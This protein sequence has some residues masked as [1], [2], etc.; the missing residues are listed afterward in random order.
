M[1]QSSW[2]NQPLF[3]CSTFKDM[4]AERDHL[5]DVVFPELERRLRGKKCH[6]EPVDLRWGVET[7]E[8]PEQEQKELLV[9]KVCLDEIDRCRPFMIVILGDRYGWVPPERRMEAAVKEKGFETEIKGK[10]VTALEIEYGILASPEQRK[11]S[12]FY[13]RKSLPYKII[14]D[15]AVYSE[16]FRNEPGAKEAYNRLIALKE[17]IKSY[18]EPKHHVREYTANWEDGRVAGLEDWGNQVL[19]DL[20]AVLEEETRKRAEKTDDTWHG[21]ERRAL[22]EFIE[23]RSRDFVGRADL[24]EH[25]RK[26][27]MSEPGQETSGV[28][29]AG[30]AGSGKSALFAKL[31]RELE[32]EAK[33]GRCF[34]LSHAAG[35]STRSD[36]IDA[37]IRRWI[38]EL[39]LCLN[40]DAKDVSEGIREFDEKK[41]VF[42]EL[43]SQV[44]AKMRVICLVDA[45]N[46]FER[47]EIAR[48]LTWLPE[49]WP[50]N[51]R[52]IA[53]A[54][55]GIETE[56]LSRKRGITR[57]DLP[58][59]SQDDASKIINTLC[60]RYHK[61]LHSDIIRELLGK[62][63]PDNTPSAGN[64][65]WLYIAIEHLLLMDEDDFSE[66]ERLPGKNDEERLHAYMVQCAR[67]YPPSVEALY[68]SLF[69]RAH[70]RFGRRAGI[71]W[72]PEMLD[73]IAV[74]RH[75]LREKDICAI[76]R[77][78]YNKETPPQDAEKFTEI[79]NREFELRFALVRRYLRAHI[80]QRGEQGLWN[81]THAQV[82]V[83]LRNGRLSEREYYRNCHKKI[84]DYLETLPREDDLRQ[85]EV[86]LHYMEGDDKRRAVLYYGSV[87]S[88]SEAMH[89]TQ[90]LASKIAEG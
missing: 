6:L 74:S 77:N 28:C 3:I 45:L 46:Q 15:P 4:Q 21:Q 71:P 89:A 27:A 52:L 65:L 14:P 30:S 25:I 59:L 84:A 19:N 26:I 7:V 10:S 11:R 22:E 43:L 51:A 78:I 60:R 53:T 16:E 56:T 5:R 17:R 73:F 24:V 37:M 75:G 36:S 47:S 68:T 49:L 8:T 62:K 12:F 76:I 63:L 33:A 55:P 80:R 67:N 13:F 48:Y 54:I 20:W 87:L 38:F 82:R 79:F 9:L 70:E 61:A 1:S 32:S 42:A 34:I 29:I 83:C 2:Y 72:I 18:K 44:S 39:A 57:I 90:V 40:P 81:F 35:I 50:K 66:A 58:L 88:A 69:N 64:P 85:Q 23:I 31:Y 86:M 41:K